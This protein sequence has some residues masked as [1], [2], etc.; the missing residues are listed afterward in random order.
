MVLQLL[1]HGSLYLTLKVGD[2][3]CYLFVTHKLNHKLLTFD[4]NI[5][6]G[7][8]LIPG[9]LDTRPY[10]AY[11]YLIFLPF[12]GFSCFFM[13]TSFFKMNI[14]ETISSC[15][16]THLNSRVKIPNF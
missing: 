3:Y 5:I 11:N 10:G 12:Y 6:N 15:V 1:H 7:N 13:F 4:K 9:I 14:K 2:P 8:F 16:H